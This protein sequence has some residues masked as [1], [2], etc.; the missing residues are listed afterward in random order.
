MNLFVWAANRLPEYQQLKSDLQQNKTPVMVTGVGGIHQ[1]HFAAAL[2]L[3]WGRKILLLTPQESEAQRIKEDI[4]RF[5]G[6]DIAQVYPAREWNLRSVQTASREYEQ[7]RIGA[8][9][10]LVEGKV[11]V[12]LA[13]VEALMQPVLPPQRL[14]QLVFTLSS[15]DSMEPQALAQ[16]LVNAGYS[17]AVQ[18]EGPGQFAL[19]GGILDVFCP[20]RSEPVRIEFWGDEIDTLTSFDPE[21]QRRTDPVDTL[22]VTP[23]LE[24]ICPDKEALAKQLI[25]MSKKCRD[26]KQKQRLE[27]DAAL[28]EAEDGS[29]NL[30]KYQPLWEQ[31]AGL[32]D[33]F[34]AD[35]LVL[36]SDLAGIRA[37]GKGVHQQYQED[38][39]LLLEEGELSKG[40]E[41]H[42]FSFSQAFSPLEK[43]PMALLETFS[44]G[45]PDLKLG[46]LIPCRYMAGSSIGGEIKVL[47]EDLAPLMEAGYAVA[48]L[49]GGEKGGLQL[50]QDLQKLGLKAD[51][52][53][54]AEEI[55]PGHILILPGSVSGGMEYPDSKFALMT[56]RR[57]GGVPKKKRK[58]YRQGKQLHSLDDLTPGDAVVHSSYGIG[59][60]QGI[61]QITNK[62]IVKDYIKIQYAGTDV[63]YVPVTQLD[64]VSRYIGPREDSKV[65][66]NRLN[67]GDWQKTKQ[68]VKKACDDMA[69]QLTR[70]YAQRM[71]QKGYAFSKDTPWQREFEERFEYEETEDQLTCIQEIKEDMERQAPM[72]RLLC[73]DVGFGKTEVALRAAFK[74]IMD[75]KQCAILCPTTILAWQHYQTALQR[76]EA[77][78][79]IRIELLSRFRTP[80]QQ[81]ETLAKLKRGEVDL[82]I[83]THR[84]VQKDVEFSD[85]GL[86]IIDEEQRFGVAHKERFKEMFRGVDVL[87]LSATPIPRTLNMAMSG[88]RDMSVIEQPPQDRHPVQTYVVEHDELFLAEAIRKE[89]RRGGQVY[90]I[91]NRVESIQAKANK[92]AALLPD[93]R[94]GVAHGKM[95]EDQL[96]DIWKQLMDHEIDVLLCTTIIETGVD[97]KNANTL[98][99]ED[100][101][102]LGLSQLYQLRGRVGR[103]TRRAYAYFTF[104][105]QKVLSEIATKRLNA[106]REFTSFGSGFRIAMRDLEIRGA[107]SVLG[108]RQHGHLEAVGYDLY[109]RLLSEALQKSKGQQPSPE[110]TECVIDLRLDAHI[111]E[112][113]IENLSQRL[114]VYKKI[115]SIQSTEQQQDVL[116]ELIDRFGDPPKSV[117]S[118]S[119]VA[120]LRNI[121]AGFGFEEIGQKGDTLL[122]YPHSLDLKLA[123]ELVQRLPDRVTVNAAGRPYLGV[124]LNRKDVPKT[125]QEIADTLS[126][127]KKSAPAS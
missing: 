39:K 18:V 113:Y 59:I 84:L 14:N 35:S 6:A 51:Y 8:L 5:A 16:K 58:K 111:P 91:H 73:G 65:K 80:K 50:A 107:G 88:I 44:R 21:T 94:I 89:L 78:P 116:D 112:Y 124:R 106:I 126:R 41:G 82:V 49:C 98:I 71:Q 105:P 109:I 120:L 123:G 61:Q 69:D 62:G 37:R 15:G 125:L 103:S 99:I 45:Y 29:L 117:V 110:A 87:T 100:A 96:S 27:E 119:R 7:Q 121:L 12:L 92:L 83:G 30:D 9:E 54:T 34:P 102:R 127:W 25:Q 20:G 85:L 10:G 19:R 40:I 76:F 86:A 17:R 79:D 75:H 81:Q 68:R 67:S 53:R 1:A 57:E 23:A 93:A 38:V 74:C 3:E 22:T 70:L 31:P 95:P 90:Y 55:Q 108:G 26:Q 47:Q 115:A 122:L 63:L 56:L 32:W 4:C 101:D 97:V 64:L 46:G 104:Q 77:Y 24:A 43:R 11:Q 52:A 66:L 72:D 33:Y 2:A 36:C 42:C 118:L 114:D 13:S 60:F 28:L 48:I